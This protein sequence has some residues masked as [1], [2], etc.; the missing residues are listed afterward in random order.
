MLAAFGN[1]ST[2]ENLR[3]VPHFGMNDASNVM[4]SEASGSFVG[5]GANRDTFR[6]HHKQE[7]ENLR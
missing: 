1:G 7:I 4:V 2:H 3:I 5:G 6:Q